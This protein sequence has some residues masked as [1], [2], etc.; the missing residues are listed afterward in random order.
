MRLLIAVIFLAGISLSEAAQGSINQFQVLSKMRPNGNVTI[1]FMG[2]NMD[3]SDVVRLI[4]VGNTSGSC[5]TDHFQYETGKVV[6]QPAGATRRYHIIQ[7]VNSGPH[8][9]YSLGMIPASEQAEGQEHA[10]ASMI[11]G[12][13]TIDG[14][15]T[16]VGG[17]QGVNYWPTILDKFD[18]S[19]DVTS[20]T[21]AC[22]NR[23]AGVYMY[24]SSLS[25]VE[26][27]YNPSMAGRSNMDMSSSSNAANFWQLCV[28]Y[29]HTGMIQ[30]T[31]GTA[32]DATFYM[33]D[34]GSYIISYYSKNGND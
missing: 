13:S 27:K 20:A 15:P 32:F 9:C 16:T 24:G 22:D 26:Y 30:S 31:A 28:D 5:Q 21:A 17:T 3:P 34:P 8:Y 23:P 19:A 7:S 18:T 29:G 4:K 10:G 12:P 33:K 25:S 2:T 14:E 6:L 11:G 1:R